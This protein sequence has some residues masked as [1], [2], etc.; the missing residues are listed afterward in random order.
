MRRRLFQQLGMKT[1]REQRGVFLERLTK[2]R[3]F[4]TVL[5]LAENSGAPLHRNEKTYNFLFFG[6]A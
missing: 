1:K 3:N 6:C 5:L 4:A 2:C